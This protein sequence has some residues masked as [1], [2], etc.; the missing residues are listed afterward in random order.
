MAVLSLNLPRRFGAELPLATTSDRTK[1]FPSLI[2]APPSPAGLS[3]LA[4]HTS[5][6]VFFVPAGSS[7]LSAPKNPRPWVFHAFPRSPE[8]ARRVRARAAYGEG[9]SG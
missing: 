1:R 5:P 8:L 6:K 2:V 7:E 3:N 9:S 4:T